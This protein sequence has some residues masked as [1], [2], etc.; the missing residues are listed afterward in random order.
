MV[1]IVG[2]LE[3]CVIVLE[4]R[5]AESSVAH[6]EMVN[7]LASGDVC[8]ASDAMAKCTE[9]HVVDRSDHLLF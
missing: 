5:W 9:V 4:V 1:G 8:K 6:V 2:S 3:A 7:H